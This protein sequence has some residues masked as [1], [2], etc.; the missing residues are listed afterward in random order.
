[1]LMYLGMLAYRRLGRLVPQPFL[2]LLG[3]LLAV[4]AYLSLPR[5]RANMQRNLRIV[6]TGSPMIGSARN[7]QRVRRLARHSMYAYVRTLFDFMNLPRMLPQLYADTESAR[8]W[9]HLDRLLE[10]GRGAVF[11]TAH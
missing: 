11:I 4:F 3:V 6:L 2:R 1:M 7:E 8:G 5:K 9:E 10:E